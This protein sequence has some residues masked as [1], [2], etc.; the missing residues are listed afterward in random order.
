[1]QRIILGRSREKRDAARLDGDGKTDVA[2][3]PPSDHVWYILNSSTGV[4]S[5][6]TFG[7]MGDIPIA[8]AY[9]R[10]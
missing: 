9:N 3:W 2:V 4:P 6:G 8:S 5:Y 7:L 10:Y 1:L